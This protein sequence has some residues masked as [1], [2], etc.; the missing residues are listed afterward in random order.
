MSSGISGAGPAF[1]V[2][3]VYAQYLARSPPSM[4]K[5]QPVI[6]RAKSE[7]IQ[8]TQW[9]MSVGVA[10]SPIGIFLRTSYDPGAR[11]HGGRS[12]AARTGR[13]GEVRPSALQAASSSGLSGRGAVG[14]KLLTRIPYGARSIAAART[15]LASPPLWKA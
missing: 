7:H 5:S 9:P 12:P 11:H 6:S 10:A 1:S 15:K 2:G 3:G 4:T 14:E 8:A 13:G